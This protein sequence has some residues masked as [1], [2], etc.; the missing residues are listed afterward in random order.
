MFAKSSVV[1]MAGD[2][3]RACLELTYFAQHS[4]Q[5]T[6]RICHARDLLG[7]G[8]NNFV[9][10]SRPIDVSNSFIEELSTIFKQTVPI[11]VTLHKPFQAWRHNIVGHV[12]VWYL[13]NEIY[14]W[15]FYLETMNVF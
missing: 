4:E 3:E 1:A 7:S 12:Y 15:M 10:L 14:K 5:N 13:R 6:W 8:S 11:P 2:A 9:I